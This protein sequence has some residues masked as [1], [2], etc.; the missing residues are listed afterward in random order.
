MLV[1]DSSGADR[2]VSFTA[3]QYNF[4]VIFKKNTH[5]NQKFKLKLAQ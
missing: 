2:Q 3:L 1:C 4:H 5:F